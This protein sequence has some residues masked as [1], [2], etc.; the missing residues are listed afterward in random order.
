VA[1]G[2]KGAPD[3]TCLGCL[4]TLGTCQSSKCSTQCKSTG[5]DAGADTGGGSDAGPEPTPTSANCKAVLAC[6]DGSGFPPSAKPSCYTV[7]KAD[8]D[9]GCASLLSGY[10]S[11]GLCK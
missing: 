7:V 3:S 1:A 5:S 11:G 10:K 8:D 6:C 9:A 4:G 2:C